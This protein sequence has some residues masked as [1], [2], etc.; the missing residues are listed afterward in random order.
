M[1]IIRDRFAKLSSLCTGEKD[2]ILLL[3]EFNTTLWN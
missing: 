2:T 1:K 3:S